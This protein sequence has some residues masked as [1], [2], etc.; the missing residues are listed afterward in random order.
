MTSRNLNCY[1]LV[2]TELTAAAGAVGITILIL[3]TVVEEYSYGTRRYLLLCCILPDII[4][5]LLYLGATI[6]ETVATAAVAGR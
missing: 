5:L 2:W 6:E 1:C 3:Y 4:L